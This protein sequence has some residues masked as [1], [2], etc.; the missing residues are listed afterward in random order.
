MT[1]DLRDRARRFHE[2]IRRALLTEWDPIG[3]RG[4]A[5]AQ[6]EYDSYVPTVYKMLISRK[7]RHEVFDY[8][9]WLETEHMAL[10]GDRRRTEKFVDR[11]MQIPDEIERAA[12]PDP[13]NLATKYDFN[14]LE[15]R[16]QELIDSGRPHDAIKIYLFMADGDPSLDGGYLGM[17]LGECYER[18]GDLHAAKY[19]Y[20]RCVEENPVVRT[21]CVEARERLKDV[22]IDDLI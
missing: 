22:N 21:S 11:L 7:P 6:D 19:W 10:T 4:I 12:I 14:A 2:A 17:R 3:V 5:Q 13:S 1:A 20:G 15:R 16:A 8:L 9:W 18:M